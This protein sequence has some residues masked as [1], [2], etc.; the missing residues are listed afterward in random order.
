VC[1][2]AP[3]GRPSRRQSWDTEEET[4]LGFS[5]GSR[6]LLEPSHELVQRHVV[7]AFRNRGRDAVQHQRLQFL[8]P[9][10]P[11]NCNQKCLPATCRLYNCFPGPSGPRGVPQ[12]GVFGLRCRQNTESIQPLPSGP[13]CPFAPRLLPSSRRPSAIQRSSGK[14]VLHHRPQP[15]EPK[16]AQLRCQSPRRL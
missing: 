5:G 10:N 16:L 7:H 1:K 15:N 8:P 3:F 2:P 12:C 6:R 11:L 9:R 4:E 14:D 13:A